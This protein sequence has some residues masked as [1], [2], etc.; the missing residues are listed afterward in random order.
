MLAKYSVTTM[1]DYAQFK[2]TVIETIVCLLIMARTNQN[3]EY[4]R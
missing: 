3:G 2:N 4:K 1:R